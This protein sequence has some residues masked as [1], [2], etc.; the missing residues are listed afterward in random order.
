MG[1][2]PKIDFVEVVFLKT[3]FADPYV[4]FV[5]D[6]KPPLYG[7]VLNNNRRLGGHQKSVDR[8]DLDH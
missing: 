3:E 1:V 8:V 7:L 4:G 2:V 6:G 5:G